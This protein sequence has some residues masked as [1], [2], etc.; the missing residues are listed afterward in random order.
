MI[1]EDIGSAPLH[2]FRRLP[3]G[4]KERVL[5]ADMPL[6]AKLEFQPNRDQTSMEW[7]EM[8]NG[9]ALLRGNAYSQ[10]LP[11]PSGFVEELVPL[12]PDRM[13]VE[14]LPSRARVYIYR[15]PEGQ[16][17]KFAQ[18]EIFHLAGLGF[19]GLTGLS[20]VG[21]AREAIG[22]AAAADRWAASHFKQGLDPGGV[23]KHPG[24]LSEEGLKNLSESFAEKNA[25]LANAGKPVVLEEGMEWQQM[26]LTSEDAQFLESRKFEIEEI[27]RYYRMPHHK[28]GIME[29]AT[30]S[31]I[32]QQA[33]EYVVDTL[34]PWAVRWEQRIL[35]QLI[36]Q[37]ELFFSEFQLDGFLRGDLKS[38]YEAYQVAW[39]NGWMNNNEIRAKENMNPRD[40]EGGDAYMRPANI[41]P[42]ETPVDQ[43]RGMRGVGGSD[44][45]AHSPRMYLLAEEMGARLV[46]KEVDRVSKAAKKYADDATGWE[47]FCKS[48]YDN[49]GTEVARSLRVP[50]VVGAAYAQRQRD[51]LLAKGASVVEDWM[52]EK[53]S[54]LARIAIEGV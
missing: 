27:A 17:Q 12:N 38:R 42:S 39:Q 7:R 45:A 5:P 34:R 28:I 49:Y 2:T 14:R 4:A 24:T 29:K 20:V 40:D 21:V 44:N 10:I 23:L 53:P 6:A 16:T 50:E 18:E 25:G 46:R 15:T 37:P 22:I 30:F 32:E 36:P 43:T 31:N 8:M 51:E 19:D 47:Q 41:V 1:A 52:A 9:H 33:V 35:L 26:S 3:G 11:G 13:K 54:E 48:F